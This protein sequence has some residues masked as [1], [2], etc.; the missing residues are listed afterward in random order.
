M[1]YSERTQ[2]ELGSG[3]QRARTIVLLSLGMQRLLKKNIKNIIKKKINKIYFV[4]T[5]V[6]LS[7]GM[8]R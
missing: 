2:P 8:Q 1:L 6:L 3:R 5:I 4:R 7:L